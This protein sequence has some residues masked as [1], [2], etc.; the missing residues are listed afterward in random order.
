MRRK[1]RNQ[2]EEEAVKRSTKEKRRKSRRSN[3]VERK[4]R[5]QHEKEGAKLLSFFFSYDVYVCSRVFLRKSSIG[6]PSMLLFNI[7]YRRCDEWRCGGGREKG[8]KDEKSNLLN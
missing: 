8:E 2:E 4:C 7:Y 3:Q 6:L 1:T 5:R